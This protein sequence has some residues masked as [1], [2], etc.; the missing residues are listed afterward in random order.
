[1]LKVR[2]KILPPFFFLRKKIRL[3]ID[4]LLPRKY[5]ISTAKAKQLR[6]HREI[7]VVYCEDD[8]KHIHKIREKKRRFLMSKDAVCASFHVFFTELIKV[9]T[10][11]PR[12]STAMLKTGKCVFKYS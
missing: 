9:T 8:T 1:M 4:F 2:H 6:M 5:F 7:F 3:R 11:L 12:R 10:H